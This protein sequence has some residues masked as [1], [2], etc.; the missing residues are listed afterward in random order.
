MA[1]LVK[2]NG[3]VAIE[4]NGE[5]FPPMMATIRTN[6]RSNMIIDREYYRELGKAG[7]RIFFLI[8]DTTWLK[9]NA[10][11]LFKEEAEAL[12]EVVPDAYIIPRIG[13]HPTNEWIKENPGEVLKYSD[14]TSPE[15][16][17]FTESYE[18]NLPGQYSM[19]SEKWREK[20]G[21]ELINTL[22]QIHSLP[23]ADRIAGCF[24]AAG[25]TSEWYYILP[26]VDEE[27]KIY[28]DFSESFKREFSEYLK[29]VYKNEENLRKQ[30]KSKDAGFDNPAIPQFE[31]HYYKNQ[32]D[33]DAITPK[34]ELA[35]SDDS[36]SP[37]N[38]TNIGSFVDM[39]NHK[40]VYDFWRAWHI[41]TANSIL[42][43]ADLIKKNYPDMLVGAFYG[44]YGCTDY[45]IN[46]TCGGTV[47]LLQSKSIDFLA[48]PPVYENRQIGGFEG[49]RQ[50][51]DSFTINN[52]MFVVEDDVR[53]HMENSLFQGRYDVYDV[54][55]SINI[56]KR[57]FGRTICIDVQSWWFDQLLGGRRYKHPEL[58]KL[59]AR[60]QKIAEFAYSQDRRKNSDIAF[61]YDEESAQAVSFKTT[62]DLVE[63]VRNYEIAKV[64]APIDEY[65][66]ND[67]ANPDMPSYKLYVFVNV[68][69]L[70]DDERK[71]IKDK[72]K[73]D[74]AVA[75][76]LY[77]P[78]IINPESD[79]KFSA[80]NIK[81][82]TGINVVAKDEKRHAKFR[83]KKDTHPML[84]AL[85]RRKLYG[86]FDR[87]RYYGLSFHM[88]QP[89]L[90]WDAY[91]S[92][93]ILSDDKD[94]FVAAEFAGSNT[95]AVTIK[96]MDG[97]TSVLYGSK[98]ITSD[99]IKEAARYAGCHIYSEGDDVLYANRGFVTIH[100]SSTGEKTLCFPKICSPYEL[101]EDK[102]YGKDVEKITFHMELGETKMFSINDSL[103]EL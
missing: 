8:C 20:A 90:L 40:D 13:L 7:I 2:H 78:G 38:G 51:F 6:N 48:S 103:P 35:N 53:T 33:I 28:G 27:K 66:H 91:L 65:F 25:G 15:A 10:L 93:V 74:N 96:E 5:I 56:M 44:A 1:K 59:I 17:L 95:P 92:P 101:Y 100:A 94:A 69:V 75:L 62:R 60:Q 71:I 47:K 54:E 50:M 49:Q 42:Y 11:E 16:Y 37:C 26:V 55:D 88:A 76:W 39:D 24:L 87:R 89:E 41:G 52:K 81:Q 23:Y 77:A 31:K 4:I 43:F 34:V 57:S 18:T 79:K 9:P 46:G 21:M 98:V 64:G 63:V 85:D 12:L 80:Q 83:V 102:F 97:W 72:L 61:I 73:K 67:M 30:W 99:F 70:T 32:V 86:R 14:G 19:C 82:L 58:Y 84:D 3:S 22:H 36:E 45:F 68:F 29:E